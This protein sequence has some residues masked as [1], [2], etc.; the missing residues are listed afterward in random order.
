M[1]VLKENIKQLF[2]VCHLYY[3][4][5]LL[6][7]Q[8]NFPSYIDTSLFIF[9]KVHLSVI[10]CRPCYVGVLNAKNALLMTGFGKF[11]WGLGEK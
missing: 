5:Q 10:V 6:L 9:N 8:W 7:P 1:L 4:I 2:T 3:N 11:G